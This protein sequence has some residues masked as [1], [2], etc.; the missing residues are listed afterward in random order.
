MKPLSSFLSTLAIVSTFSA[1]APTSARAENDYEILYRA[2]AKANPFVSAERAAEGL[3]PGFIMPALRAQYDA[4][5]YRYEGLAT[6]RHDEVSSH[7]ISF[8]VTFDDPTVIHF[9]NSHAPFQAD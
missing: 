6:I 9:G 5:V 2:T 7:A 1:L 4:Y 3:E 8:Y